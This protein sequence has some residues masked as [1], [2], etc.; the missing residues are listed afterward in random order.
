MA[1]ETTGSFPLLDKGTPI[2]VTLG[3][4]VGLVVTV[5]VVVGAYYKTMGQ[6][7]KMDSKLKSIDEKLEASASDRWT[8]AMMESWVDEAAW[9]NPEVSLPDVG[10]IQLRYQKAVIGV[11]RPMGMKG[12]VR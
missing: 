10:K 2:K 9:M 11:A 3:A 5:A 4:L 8:G 7:E 6:F 12:E 1:K